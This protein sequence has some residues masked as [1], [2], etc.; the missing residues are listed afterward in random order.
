MHRWARA[1]AGPSPTRRW[2]TSAPGSAS[3]G[4][5]AVGGAMPGEEGE[6]CSSV[7]VGD[8]VAGAGQGRA[9]SA[10][11]AGRQSNAAREAGRGR[12]SR[13]TIRAS[14]SGSRSSTSSTRSAGSPACA[15]KAAK[16]SGRGPGPEGN[17][18]K[19]LMSRIT[20]PVTRP[21][22]RDPR[23]A[24]DAHGPRDAGRGSG[25][26]RW[27]C[28][29]RRSSIYGGSDEMQKNIIGE[30]V[31]GLPKEPDADRDK[32]MPVPRAQGRDATRREL[33]ARRE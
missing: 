29:R 16:A 11:V 2:R 25:R 3:G 24:R 21:R 6:A 30:R 1:A 18:A 7:R 26:R 22:S 19:L 28:S 12:R 27:R 32:K 15:V 5:G 8:L 14:A 4:S 23:A 33:T 10:R 17:T 31:L 9:P 13:P 20:A